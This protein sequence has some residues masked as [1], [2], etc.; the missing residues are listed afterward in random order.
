MALVTLYSD[1]KS[2]LA[3]LVILL[4]FVA[5]DVS[6]LSGHYLPPSYHKE[7]HPQQQH[8]HH[9]DGIQMKQPPL[10][11]TSS[12]GRVE[13]TIEKHE[14]VELPT[15]I[16]IV[17]EGQ[18]IYGVRQQSVEMLKSNEQL[19][20]IKSQFLPP[21]PEIENLQPPAIPY[22]MPMRTYLPPL[23]PDTPTTTDMPPTTTTNLP[24]TTT[25]NPAT[26]ETTTEQQMTTEENTNSLPTTTTEIPA[27]EQQSY[28]TTTLSPETITMPE[29]HYLPSNTPYSMPQN[30]YL[31]PL[32]MMLP[33][34]EPTPHLTYQ[35]YQ[36][37]LM[38]EQHMQQ[39]YREQEME[40]M[41]HAIAEMEQQNMITLEPQQQQQQQQQHQQP[42]APVEPAHILRDDGYHYKTANDNLRRYRYRH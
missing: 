27:S 8:F 12:N 23:V 30:H 25:Y 5:A 29:N 11:M 41:L 1:I 13:T 21:T 2:S 7:N 36:E 26:E 3:I 40:E 14:L 35:Q 6:H 34:P 9:P 22:E 33:P 20:E 32:D 24:P 42:V 17:K 18:P 4:A 15:Q 38:H 31:S 16:E 39:M 19:A 37:Q 28:D 10:P